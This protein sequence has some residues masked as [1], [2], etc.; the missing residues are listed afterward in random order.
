VNASFSGAEGGGI[1]KAGQRAGEPHRRDSGGAGGV[2]DEGFRDRKGFFAGLGA[3]GCREILGAEAQGDSAG[4]GA[5]DGFGVRQRLGGFHQHLEPQVARR[6]AGTEFAL[7]HQLVE[8]ADVVRASGL[9]D[10]ETIDTWDDGGTDVVHRE[11]ERGVDP[12][13]HVRAALAHLWGAG[14]EGGAGGGLLVGGDGI[15]EVEQDTVGAA[16][17]R[18]LDEAGHVG[19]NVELRAPDRGGTVHGSF[20]AP[21]P[22]SAMSPAP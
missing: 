3:D 12:H 2:K 19:G 22:S 5:G 1:A 9:G 11:R 17:M 6:D 16:G 15:L 20:T 8:Q 21:W 7:R 18:L 4:A 10:H 14:G 13:Q